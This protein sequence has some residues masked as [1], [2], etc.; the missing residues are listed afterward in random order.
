[1]RQFAS[2]RELIVDAHQH[3]PSV[4][5]SAGRAS[6]D[7]FIIG[8][9]RLEC[10]VS[11]FEE[12]HLLLSAPQQCVT[13]PLITRTVPAVT[14]AAQFTAAGSTSV[15]LPKLCLTLARSHL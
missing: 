3:D 11:R 12:C 15:P 10:R 2:A 14:P 9:Y 13:I 8:R 4:V 6:P 7:C 1:M 5:S